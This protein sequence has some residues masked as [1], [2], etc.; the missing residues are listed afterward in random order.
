MKEKIPQEVKRLYQGRNL[1]IR[2]YTLLRWWLCPFEKMEKY[3]PEEG[4][5]LDLGCGYGLLANFLSLK[6]DKRRVIGI[7]NSKRRLEVAKS[8]IGN[9]LNIKFIQADI[10]QSD[11]PKCRGVVMTDFLHHLPERVLKDLLEKVFN[12]LEPRGALIIEEVSNNPFWKYIS[13]IIVDKLLYPNQKI[14]FK[15][16]KEWEKILEQI[17]FRVKIIPAH[18]S[19]PLADVILVCAK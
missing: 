6:S 17:G 1:S 2:L 13:S 11:L 14:N 9:R 8:T 4:I 10:I 18:Q 15:P 16:A 19:L 7:D 12:S 5:I 3:L